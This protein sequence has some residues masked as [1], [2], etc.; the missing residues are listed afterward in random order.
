L[1]GGSDSVLS[2]NAPIS[3]IHA[4]AVDLVAL[5]QE[6]DGAGESSVRRPAPAQ[7]DDIVSARPQRPLEDTSDLPGATGNDALHGVL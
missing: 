3:T 6:L 7:E 5:D 4:V 1:S 2:T